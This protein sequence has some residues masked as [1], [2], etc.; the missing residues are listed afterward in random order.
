MEDGKRI[1]LSVPDELYKEIEELNINIT[2]VA[3]SALLKTV[4]IKKTQ[5]DLKKGYEEMAEINSGLAETG[6][7]AENEALEIQEQYLRNDLT[8][9]E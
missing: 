4:K 1:I 8:E 6:L 9:S 5:A 2:D 3:L 7:E